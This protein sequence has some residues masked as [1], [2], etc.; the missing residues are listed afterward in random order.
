[1]SG[2]GRNFDIAGGL[3]LAASS[4]ILPTSI[5]PAT[6]IPTPRAAPVIAAEFSLLRISPVG[7][8]L[9]DREPGVSVVVS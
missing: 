9:D 6:P 1:M 5:D 8:S 7:R 4:R 2:S 3:H